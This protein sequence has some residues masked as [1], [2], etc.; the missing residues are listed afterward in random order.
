MAKKRKVVRPE[1]ALET[2]ARRLQET[3]PQKRLLLQVEED[4]DFFFGSLNAMRG[5][6]DNRAGRPQSKG[7]ANLDPPMLE[8]MERERDRTGETRRN[9]LARLATE[10]ANLPDAE[11]PAAIKRLVR[12]WVKRH[13]QNSTN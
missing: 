12:Q 11:R 5:Y 10:H 13:G 3:D 8:F 9:T 2:K 6:R 7:F 4:L 1:D